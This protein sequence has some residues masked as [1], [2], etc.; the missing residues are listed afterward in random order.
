VMKMDC[1]DPVG[2]NTGP[3]AVPLNALELKSSAPTK[4]GLL[5]SEGTGFV[6]MPAEFVKLA[7]RLFCGV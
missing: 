2:A 3:V 5:E 7:I 4:N 1:G 6:A